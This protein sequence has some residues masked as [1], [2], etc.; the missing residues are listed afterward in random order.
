MPIDFAAIA[1]RFREPLTNQTKPMVPVFARLA[2]AVE[3]LAEQAE[4]AE[5]ATRAYPVLRYRD[6]ALCVR[7]DP[8]GSPLLETR[9][10]LG[11]AEGLRTGGQEFL[12]GIGWTRT[13]AQQELALPRVL[14]VGAG[15]LEA[16][17]ESLERFAR[18][19]P[20]MFDP[21]ERR[22][23]DVL[24]LLV[25][26]YNSLLGPEARD[27][28]VAVAGG[29]GRSMIFYRE[30]KRLFP[31]PPEYAS[32]SSVDQWVTTFEDK[33]ALFLD[34]VLLLPILGDVLAVAVHDGSLAAKRMILTELTE[35]EAKVHA[36][37]SAALEGLI[38]GADLGGLAARWLSAASFV[39]LLDV[40]I[41]TTAIPSLLDAL[42]TSTRLFAEGITE[43]GTWLTEL[44]ELVRSIVEAIMGFDL[45]GFALRVV[46]PGWVID[47]LPELPTFTVDDL[48]S[49]LIGEAV[50]GIR[51]TLND[52]FGATLLVLSL[53]GLD[54]YYDKVADLAE[55]VNIV[56]TP[57]PFTLPPDVMPTTPL[58][59][60]PDIYEA[61]FGGG[62][63]AT[64][65]GAIDS[66]GSE[67]RTAIRSTLGGAETLM[68][69]LG[70]TFA[71]EADR[72]AVMGSVA[73]MREL[74]VDA[75]G[76]AETVFGPEAE[77]VREQ[78]ARRRPDA[79]AIAFEGAVTS[80]GFA[81]V[82]AAIPA[83]VRA[84][85]SFWTS[86]RPPADRPT[87][88]HILARHGRLG[89][90]RVPRMTVR[91]P[92]RTAD[93]ELAAAVAARFHDEVGNAYVGG[94]RE[95]ERLGGPPLHREPRRA[96]PRRGGTGRG[97]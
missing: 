92:G 59:G 38:A 87:S 11:F 51:D 50:T 37:R 68:A 56:L 3:K 55:V 17:A 6:G 76:M 64:L 48:I 79:L 22:L 46:L 49:L 82:G 77:R 67:T 62:R 24:G 32:M 2:E 58:A 80:G 61:F 33:A 73:R 9:P 30:Y 25:L 8:L 85:R 95:F 19:T 27:Q 21:R 53:P 43:W 47:L 31:D 93:R 23:S 86:R 70:T 13:A 74:A 63:A 97:R 96:A 28:L 94:R 26:G 20:Q 35:L 15:A 7:V 65:L 44:A 91:A 40:D 10:P 88:P 29:A 57:R 89:G 83:Y 18:P 52:W 34:L 84:M 71:A 54:Y 66:L 81:L 36:M 5:R 1:D 60:F 41:L 69:D 4:A 72:A 45:L 14:G 12:A 78:A 90:V 16:V 42:L 75:A 39:V